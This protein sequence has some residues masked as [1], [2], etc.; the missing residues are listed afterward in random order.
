MPSVYHA[1]V[2]RAVSPIYI[3]L[4]CWAVGQSRKLAKWIPVSFRFVKLRALATTLGGR[5]ERD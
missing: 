1:T 5:E 2:P 3:T 4:H